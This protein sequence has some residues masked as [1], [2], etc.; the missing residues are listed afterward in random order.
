MKTSLLASASAIRSACATPAPGASQCSTPPK[1]TTPTRS[2][3]RRWASASPA[4]ARTAR[5]SA[6]RGRAGRDVGEGVDEDEH[7]RRALGMALG[8]EGL[9]AA[10]RRAPMQPSRV[11]AGNPRPHLGQL[12]PLAARA[13]AARPDRGL[14]ARRRHER[15]QA[16]DARQHADGGLGRRGPGE[17][18]GAHAPVARTRAPPA[19][20]RPS[21]WPARAG[22]R[23]GGRPRPG[24]APAPARLG[25][26]SRR[27]RGRSSSQ[28]APPSARTS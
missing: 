18:H 6:P 19:R 12:E 17:P 10:R 14:R 15:A 3:T 24:A 2:R 13:R 4:A 28:S 8:D 9:A 20:C 7:V 16:L 11:I 5:V 26:Q 22:R 21:A 23:G 1:V 27:Q 25:H